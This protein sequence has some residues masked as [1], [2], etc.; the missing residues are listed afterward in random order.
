MVPGDGVGTVEAVDDPAGTERII[1][2]GV[3]KV[4]E[5]IAG[6]VAPVGFTQDHSLNQDLG[7]DLGI[8][9]ELRLFQERQA[10]QI[11][12]P[13]VIFIPCQ[14]DITP[15]V[16][17]LVRPRVRLAILSETIVE[18]RY[19]SEVNTLR[20]REN[21]SLD[22]SKT[23]FEKLGYPSNKGG[24]E[25]DFIKFLDLDGEVESFIKINETQH[26]FSSIFYIRQDGLLSKYSPDFLVKTKDKYHIVE[27]KGEDRVDNANVKQKQLATLEWCKKINTLNPEFRDNREWEYVLISD[28]DF[29]S[30][31]K[32]GANFQDICKYCKVVQNTIQG[33]LF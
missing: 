16:V 5:R 29:Y 1:A 12:H 6:E 28:N 10:H 20:I 22:V 27:T 14:L 23:I 26:M 33:T 25:K 31:S 2:L 7:R 17:D 4:L 21:Y 32:N 30:W 8:K 13:F 15:A 18:K 11:T 3:E 9:S 19:F 24:L